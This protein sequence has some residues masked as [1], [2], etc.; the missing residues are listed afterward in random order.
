MTM[1]EVKVKVKMKMMNNPLPQ[2]TAAQ[3]TSSKL[4]V[5]KSNL[6]ATTTQI[7]VLSPLKN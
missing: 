6:V 5:T 2:S 7:A 3:Q 4:M 1:I